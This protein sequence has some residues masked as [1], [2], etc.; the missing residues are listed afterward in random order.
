LT[1]GVDKKSAAVAR[2]V[3]GDGSCDGGDTAQQALIETQESAGRGAV[4]LSVGET[5]R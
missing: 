3:S 5:R 2:R 4:R 1:N